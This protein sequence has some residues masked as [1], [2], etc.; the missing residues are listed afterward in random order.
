[1]RIRLLT[2]LLL[3]SVPFVPVACSSKD[4]AA[5]PPPTPDAD[6]DTG[7]AET[8]LDTAPETPPKIDFCAN[9]KL[10]VR[11]FSDD[12]GGTLRH[13]L[14][15]DFTV[16]LVGGETFH[17]K[18]KW[19]G[20]E[21]YV[22]VPELSK[23]SIDTASIW[24][25][26]LDNLIKISP[27]NVRY[28]FV[29]R[30]GTDAAADA[31]TAAMND[32]IQALLATLPEDQAAHW[33]ERLLV[34]QGRIGKY[35]NW[36]DT[37]LGGIGLQGFAIDRAQKIRGIGSF[38]D[39][40]RYKT[41]LKDAGA[42][43][44]EANLAYAS[45]EG[46]M[47]NFEAT[48]DERLAAQKATVVEFYKGEVLSE[49]DEKDVTLPSA[50]EMANFDTLE[51]D[52]DS[53]CPDVNKPEFNNCGA[54]DYI[55]ALY[56]YDEKGAKVEI[57]RFITSYHRE[58]HWLVDATPM[59]PLLKAGGA[60]KF[61]WEFAPPWN[62]QPTGTFLSLRFSNQKKPVKP[63]ST[64]FLWSGGDFGSKYDDPHT[65]IDVPIPATAKKV[66]LVTVI[67]GHG[68]GT[69]QCSEFCNHQH[70]FTVN[71]TK[72]LREFKIAG[73]NKGCIDEVDK[74]MVP[75]QGGT[76]W[77]GRGGWCPGEQV[78]PWVQDVTDKVTPGT[79]AK[80]SY[81][82]MYGGTAPPPDGS[83]NIDLTSWLV[84]YE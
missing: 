83:G 5:P 77:F 66:Q 26:D 65:P 24:E 68:S 49:F 56:V 48:R 70:E 4:E 72:Y 74:G 71:G 58:T 82:G 67:T 55:A 32:R 25:K 35:G 36:L 12:K 34:V 23:S 60:R 44:W 45:Y 78:D 38:A 51:V 29:T 53:R 6:P 52:I 16:N 75:N 33:R 62:K 30:R 79:T 47:F 21:S 43:P 2:I 28:F 9:E 50:S 17:F 3:A 42:W 31:T 41:A 39:V 40:T 19:T 69:N 64:T 11:P 81:R 73:N 13:E 22:F 20:C 84:V 54:W 7:G 18:E 61:R 15:A 57:A 27:R 8:E 59:L 80:V 63:T 14:A 10:P 1:V 76:W 37:T 46:R